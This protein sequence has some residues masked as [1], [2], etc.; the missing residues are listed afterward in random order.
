MVSPPIS[1]FFAIV[2]LRNLR[3]TRISIRNDPA[4]RYL[5]TD[6]L[7]RDANQVDLYVDSG[8]AY[9]QY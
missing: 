3:R 8:E 1:A 4:Q 2:E 6:Y 9:P 7:S 5:T